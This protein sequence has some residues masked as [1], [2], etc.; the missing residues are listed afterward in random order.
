MFGS[1]FSFPSHDSPFTGRPV[2]ESLAI[3]CETNV[4]NVSSSLWVKKDYSPTQQIVPNGGS[5]TRRKNTYIFHGVTLDDAGLFICKATSPRSKEITRLLVFE[6]EER[7]RECIYRYEGR[8]QSLLSCKSANNKVG[9]K[10]NRIQS[11]CFSYRVSGS[12]LSIL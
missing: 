9:S 5:I 2:G 12:S 7:N 6:G 3:S 4:Q 10:D 1:R 8:G 11:I